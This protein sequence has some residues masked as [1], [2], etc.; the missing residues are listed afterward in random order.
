MLATQAFDKIVHLRDICIL[1]LLLLLYVIT[2]N[3]KL[4]TTEDSASAILREDNGN[5][6]TISADEIN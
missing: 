4:T 5:T 1:L 3:M 2:V 6:K